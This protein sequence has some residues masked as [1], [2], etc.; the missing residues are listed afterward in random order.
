MSF[1][2]SYLI[3]RPDFSV[4]PLSK[5]LMCAQIHFYALINCKFNLNL[6]RK[7]NA[8]LHFAVCLVDVVRHLYCESK[9]NP[10]NLE[11]SGEPNHLST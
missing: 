4:F 2:V 7:L 3:F 8:V 10:Q 5:I 11:T 1:L 9:Q 6:K